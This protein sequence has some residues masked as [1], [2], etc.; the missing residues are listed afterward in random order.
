[1]LFSRWWPN[2]RSTHPEADMLLK[3]IWR[4]HVDI[5]E[6]HLKKKAKNTFIPN[7]VKTLVLELIKLIKLSKLSKAV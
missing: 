6:K 2:S 3:Q 5:V 1:M 7:L 4:Q